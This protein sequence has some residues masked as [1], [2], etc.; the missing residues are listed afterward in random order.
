[1]RG[2]DETGGSLFSHGD[3][4]ARVP[5]RHPLRKI[6]QVVNEALSGLDAESAALYTDVGRRSILP[7]RLI[8]ASLIRILFSVRL[9]PEAGLRHDAA[10]EG[11]DAR[12]PLVPLVRRSRDRRS[13]LG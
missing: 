3:P 7:E 8:R 4:E 11:A 13:R 5:A 9:T 10:A 2:A 12:Q 6:R 1:M